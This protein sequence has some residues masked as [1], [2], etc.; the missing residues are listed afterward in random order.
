MLE[1]TENEVSRWGRSVQ[2]GSLRLAEQDYR[3]VDLVRRINEDEFLSD[4]LVFKGGTALNKLYFEDNARLSVDLDFN[5]LGTR[6]SVQ[7]E[8][9]EM[10]NRLIDVLH[11]QDPDFDTYHEH[12]WEMLRVVG[13][14]QPLAAE[15]DE[16]I[17]IECSTVERF[18]ITETIHK[19][20][21]LP[22]GDTASIRTL[23]IDE[24]IATKVRALYGRRKGRDVYDLIQARPLLERPELLRKM[25]I[26]YFYRSQIVYDPDLIEQ[27]MTDESQ[28]RGFRQ[29]I[30][31]FL[32]ADADFD[33]EE[34]ISTLPEAYDFLFD[35]D[36]RD[37]EFILLARH[38]L[39]KVGEKRAADVLEHEHPLAWLFEGHS[40]ISKRALEATQDTIYVHTDG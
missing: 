22:S 13:R 30:S 26:Y 12:S 10:R 8:R 5:V 39:G 31:P 15:T 21:E 38:L 34:A 24:L 20:L 2:M 18:P 36:E 17:K 35:L 27:A 25:A 23:P 29:D 40:G 37:E 19:P 33:V 16:K 11:D 3:L 9:A 4:R 32:R 14:Y 28:L 1:L 7:D 6:D